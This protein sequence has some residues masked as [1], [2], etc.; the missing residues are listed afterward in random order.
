MNYKLQAAEENRKEL[1][2]MKK[3]LTVI[4]GA[5]NRDT[6]ARPRP[7]KNTDTTF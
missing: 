1:A 2:P 5:L 7:D 4:D 3:T 6:D